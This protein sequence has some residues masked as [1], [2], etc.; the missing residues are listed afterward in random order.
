[1]YLGIAS[2]TKFW[3]SPKAPDARNNAEHLQRSCKKLLKKRTSKKLA[4]NLQRT[5]MKLDRT[6]KKLA[7]QISNSPTVYCMLPRD[8][9]RNKCSATKSGCGQITL[10]FSCC[11][12]LYLFIPFPAKSAWIHSLRN[13]IV[14]IFV[15][16][17]LCILY[18]DIFCIYIYIYIYIRS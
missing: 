4:E 17:F 9:N 15:F 13:T 7:K 3:H 12:F 18:L 11:L 6:S 2:C 14:Q 8:T 10:C 1:M 5:S 16:R